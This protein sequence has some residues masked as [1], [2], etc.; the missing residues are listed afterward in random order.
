MTKNIKVPDFTLPGTCDI[1]RRDFLVGGAA[2]LL[3]GGCGSGGAEGSSTGETRS[4]EGPMGTVEVPVSP[5]RVVPGYTTDIDVALVLQLP[6]VGAPGARGGAG[7]AFASYQPEGELEDL[8]KITT[9]V[10]PNLEQI[11]A[12]EPDV[13]ID[14]VPFDYGGDERYEQ[15]SRI[16]PTLNVGDAYSEGWKPYLRAVAGA[17]GREALAEEFISE[18]EARAAGLKERISER[19]GGAS[20]ALAS[21]FETGEVFLSA[22]EAQPARILR[23]DLGLLTSEAVPET[24]EEQ[25]GISLERLDLL[26]DADLLVVRVEPAQEGEGRDREVLDETQSS[27]LWQRLPAVEAGN[28]FEYDAELFYD[29]PLSASAFLDLVEESL[30]S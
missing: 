6:L 1:T 4:V 14:S 18:Y 11:A 8:E 12:L 21:S 29:S 3:L 13:I 26:E 22:A 9:F 17:F 27:P 7:E 30:L 24:F 5:Q 23:D 16:A 19:W 20:F 10:E 2:A 25:R 28:V 15:F